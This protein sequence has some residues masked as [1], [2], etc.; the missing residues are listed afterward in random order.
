MR[1]R[2]Q[3]SPANPAP[4]MTTR[5]FIWLGFIWLGVARS[6][7][8][9][10]GQGPGRSTPEGAAWTAVAIAARSTL[11]TT[12]VLV[13]VCSRNLFGLDAATGAERWRYAFAGRAGFTVEF[14]I[15]DGRVYA[16]DG[17]VVVCL[18]QATGQ[19]LGQIELASVALFGG[20]HQGRARMVVSDGH[21]F[22][23]KGG[24]VVSMRLADGQVAWRRS[25]MEGRDTAL[26]FEGNIRPD[27]S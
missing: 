27:D 23:G 24:E 19:P 4:T 20:R 12:R 5:L 22:I 7:S 1:R 3:T 6:A 15:A 25:L 13:V 2:A 14:A 8:R 11:M 16:C 10:Q 9:G 21:L 18:D 26:G 17:F